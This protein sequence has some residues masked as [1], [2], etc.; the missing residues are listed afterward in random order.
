MKTTTL[1]A[2]L[3]LLATVGFA[4]AADKVALCGT[5]DSQE[6]LRSLGAAFEKAN[7]GVAVVVPDSVGSD[8][9]VKA[10]AAG[11]CDFGRVARPLKDEEKGL[12]LTYK[13]IAYSPIVIVA[14][15]AAGV[16]DLTSDQLVRIFG[17]KVTAWTEVG[18]KGGKI[19]VVNREAKDSSRG[20]LNK[21]VEG[22]KAIENPAGVVAAKTPEAVELLSKTPNAIGYLPSAMT[23]GLKLRIVKVN[24]IA[25]TAA[26][27]LQGK[28]AIAAPFGLVWKGE[29]KPAA[30]RF[31]Q[32]LKSAEGKK[33]II[34]Y[35]TV[36]ADLL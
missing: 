9:G 30:A 5:G 8:G 20:E 33:I 28:Y 23:K 13:V 17:G 35:G 25:P 14:D 31:F 11:E 16:E 19:A 26:N 22:F 2:L 34:D 10:A 36:P 32:F 15:P 29:F 1:L 24:G 12:G 4:G 21:R 18:G 6:L 3:L 7:P 27:V